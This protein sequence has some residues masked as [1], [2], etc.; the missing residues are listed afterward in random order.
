M[1]RQRLLAAAV[2][3]VILGCAAPWPAGQLVEAAQFRR[4]T[5]I[6]RPLPPPEGFTRV[7]ALSP[8]PR[9]LVERAI[10]NFFDQWNKAGLAEYLSDKFYDKQRLVDQISLSAP[11][12]ARIRLLSLQAVATLGQFERPAEGDA[13]IL[14]SRVSA[15][16]Q[17]QVEF[18]SPVTG[19]NQ[20]AGTHEYNFTITSR[21][22]AK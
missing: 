16:A 18:T 7:A 20:L 17:T 3:A 1:S 11:R 15:I 21:V 19:F 4:I 2:T 14:V 22:Q 10:R 9:P 6:A 12:D 13:R 5:P 8:L